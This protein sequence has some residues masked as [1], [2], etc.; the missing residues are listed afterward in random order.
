MDIDDVT[1]AL[2]HALIFLS[3]VLKCSIYGQ[4]VFKIRYRI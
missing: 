2:K 4:K 3:D 1:K